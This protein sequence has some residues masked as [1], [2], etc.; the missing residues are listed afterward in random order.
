LNLTLRQITGRIFRPD[1][2]KDRLRPHPEIAIADF[3]EVA[4]AAFPLHQA[5]AVLQSAEKRVRSI[6]P[7]SGKRPLPYIPQGIMLPELVGVDGSL[8]INVADADA[9]AIAPVPTK[10]LPDL[11][12]P[13]RV[14]LPFSEV[15]IHPVGVII[16]R[17]D[18]GLFSVLAGLKGSGE[19][20][21]D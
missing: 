6:P 20:Q 4:P 8:G 19:D 11:L 21:V 2:L 7:N 18:L 16:H 13:L 14:L 3:E 5:P 9:G 12:R 1:I 17:Q 15:E 10:E